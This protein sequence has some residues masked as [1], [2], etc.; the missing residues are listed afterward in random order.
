[1]SSVTVPSAKATPAN[2]SN[3]IDL[4]IGSLNQLLKESSATSSLLKKTQ[5]SAR[6]GKIRRE[7]GVYTLVHEYFETDLNAVSGQLSLSQQAA[8][9]QHTGLRRSAT[10]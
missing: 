8:R 4:I 6:Q 7:N 10:I 5:V 2:S 9:T 3:G 1:M